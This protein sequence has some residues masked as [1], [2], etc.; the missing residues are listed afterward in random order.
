MDKDQQIKQLRESQ[1]VLYLENAT[2]KSRCHEMEERIAHLAQ[3]LDIAIQ[4][5]ETAKATF[6]QALQAADQSR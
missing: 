6:E 3:A 4:A 2:L 5:L 1:M